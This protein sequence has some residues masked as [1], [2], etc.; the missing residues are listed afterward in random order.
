MKKTFLIMALLIMLL[1]NGNAQT[2]KLIRYLPQDANMIMSFNPVKIASYIPGET[3]RQS[4]IYR[5]MMKEDNG[6]LRAFLSDPAVS[7][8]DFNASLILTTITDTI[9]S[10]RGNDATISIFGLLRNEA[11]F[12]LAVQKISKD[13]ERKIQT[14]GT[15]KILM[16]GRTGPA[17]AW[18]DEIFVFT[19]GNRAEMKREISNQFGAVEEVMADSVAAMPDTIPVTKEPDFDLEKIYE[20]FNKQLRNY[21]FELLTP[22]NSNSFLSNTHFTSLL[23]EKGDIKFWSNNGGWASSL[24][25]LPPDVKKIF[26][27]LNLSTGTDRTGVLNFENGKITSAG[28]NYLSAEQDAIYKKYNQPAINTSLVHKLPAMAR[29]IMMITGSVQPEMM[30]EIF[31]TTG[32]NNMLDEQRE[33]IPFNPSLISSSFGTSGLFAVVSVPVKE[34]PATDTDEYRS[35]KDEIFKGL[36][37]IMAMPVKN[38]ISLNELNDSIQSLIAKMEEKNKEEEVV[39]DDGEARGQR[40]LG[41]LKGIKPSYKYNDSFFVF[42]TSEELAN[43]YISNNSITE[44][45]AFLSAQSGYSMAMN[46]GLKNFINLMYKNA[47][48]PSSA[49]DVEMLKMF[50]MFGDMNVYSGKYENGIVTNTFDMQI[51]KADENSFKQIFELLN[52]AAEAKAKER[53]EWMNDDKKIEIQEETKQDVEIEMPPPP[54]PVKLKI[55]KAPVKKTKAK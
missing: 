48:S 41:I 37:I 43:A 21:C 39:E 19:T 33:K 9:A 18:N 6:E 28:K 45:P 55:N 38:K 34:K 53:E 13:E 26:S 50:N 4:A 29:P 7:G 22:K 5:Q 16:T 12:S 8:I 35:K 32:L 11:L 40:G 51:G 31:K 27:K 49:E 30:K 47:G 17:I 2:E 14:Y 42:S 25:R 46:F 36:H 3:F 20:K 24:K 1:Q 23:E 15:N 54:P 52:K 10:R 44:T